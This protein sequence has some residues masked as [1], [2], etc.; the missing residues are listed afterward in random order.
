MRQ[1][2]VVRPI[3]ANDLDRYVVNL[4]LAIPRFRE[5]ARIYRASHRMEEAD[6]AARGASIIMEKLRKAVAMRAA[7]SNG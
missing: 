5:A 7:A 6:H 1:F 3:P 2:R 4:E